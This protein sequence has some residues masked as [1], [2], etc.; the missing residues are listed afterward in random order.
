MI[1]AGAAVLQGWT[2]GMA[3]LVAAVL[4]WR[5]L[6]STCSRSTS[7]SLPQ[8]QMTCGTSGCASKLAA[9]PASIC[10]EV[11]GLAD[12]RRVQRGGGTEQIVEGEEDG[13]Q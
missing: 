1:V 7:T 13:D 4:P 2:R 9:V 10:A 11:A 6:T 3:V 8:I 5:P 12:L